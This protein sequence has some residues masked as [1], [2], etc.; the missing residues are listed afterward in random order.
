[1]LTPWK[2]SYDKP[3]QHIKKQRHY[4]ANKGSYSQ[5][6]G[7]SSSPVWMWG[8]DYKESWALRNWCFWTVVLE[9][10]LESPL[11]CKEIKPVNPKGNQSWIFTRRTDAEAEAPILWP[12]HAKNWFIK[13]DPDAGKDWRQEEK[14]LTE[15]EMVG[16]HHQLDRHEFEQTLGD[17]E[18]QG[19]LACCSPWG[20]EESDMT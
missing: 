19:S 16:W 11:D 9:K 7:F 2:K 10:T 13:K 14:G 4:F 20:H 15:D 17:S 6:Y 3:R 18:A 1:M 12:P 8:L 5:G